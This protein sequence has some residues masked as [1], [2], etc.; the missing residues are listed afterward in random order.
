MLAT[1]GILVFFAQI[2]RLL[3]IEGWCGKKIRWWFE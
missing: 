2:V 1:E 3:D